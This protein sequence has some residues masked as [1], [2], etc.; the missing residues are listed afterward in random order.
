MNLVDRLRSDFG[1]LVSLE[2]VSPGIMR[3]YAPFFHEDG[4]MVSMY[5]ELRQDKTMIIRDFGNTLMRIS[6]TFELDSQNKLNV[7]S[8]IVKSNYGQL[9]DGELLL[10]TTF[11]RLPQDIFQFS[12]LVAK[13][14]SIDLLR[15]ETIRSLFFENLNEFITGQLKQY[16]FI[17][18]YLPT[19]DK[20]LI[21]DYQIPAPSGA[22]KPLFI[23]GVNENTKASKVVISCLSFQK[24]RIPFRSLIIHEDF[25]SLS[26]F[27]RN[28]I[29]NTADKQYTS[30]DD[31]KAEG[32][33]YIERELEAS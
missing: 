26:S 2:E 19:K 9:E 24:Q 11:E 32:L 8:N 10:E 16:H 25:G 20:Q 29:T 7:L 5:L 28:Q 15:R 31:F 3:I 18:N 22:M 33:D 4:D 1:E 21:V 14:S 13:V 30:L 23:F 6:Y 12:Q 27:N 17:Q